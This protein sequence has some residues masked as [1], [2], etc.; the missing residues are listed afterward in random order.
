[1]AKPIRPHWTHWEDPAFSFDGI[2]P[3]PGAATTT[4]RR[5]ERLE[6]KGNIVFTWRDEVGLSEQSRLIPGSP[7]ARRSTP[8]APH[9]RE[10]SACIAARSMI[11]APYMK[12]RRAV[13]DHRYRYSA[14]NQPLERGNRQVGAIH[15]FFS[16]ENLGPM[17]GNPGRRWNAWAGGSHAKFFADYGLTV[18]QEH[19]G[20][21][22]APS[23]YGEGTVG[24]GG[25]RRRFFPRLVTTYLR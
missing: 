6:R 25:A 18:G 12:S 10:F 4:I 16:G 23:D 21:R 9:E 20:I 19:D 2:Y 1:M 3:V 5:F 15:G 14:I 7:G 17:K 22:A 13:A 8:P 11:V 24:Q